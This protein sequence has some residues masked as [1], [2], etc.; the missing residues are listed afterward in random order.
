MDTQMGVLIYGEVNGNRLGRITLEL[1]GAGRK[2]ADK[3]KEKLGVVLIS[4]AGGDLAGEAIQYGADVVYVVD[5]PLMESYEPDS[6]IAY[7]LKVM[8]IKMPKILLLGNTDIGQDFAPRLAF[9]LKTGLIT[10]CIALSIDPQSGRMVQTKQ[11]YG[12]KVLS[13][14]VCE[15][16]PQM[17]AVRPRTMAVPEKDAAR[18]GEIVTIQ[19]PLDENQIRV[20]TLEKITETSTGIKL[21][22]AEIII[23]GG[24]GIGSAE[25]FRELEELASLFD[26]AVVGASR[27]PCDEGWIS[28]RNQ[29]GITGKIVAPRL[30]FAV[31]ISG[32]SQHVTGCSGSQTIIAMNKDKNA[33]VFR[34]SKFGVVGDWKTTLPAFREKVKELMES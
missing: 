2:L 13:D 4:Q 6:H 10:D 28:S 20:K 22:D 7:M 3:I 26:N 33:P 27:P 5:N 12:G 17:A 24:R 25:G 29:V 15:S 31:A 21:E 14:Y 16:F 32:A 30:Y 11:V 34:L 8:E 18:E 1:I 19:H 9:R 23:S